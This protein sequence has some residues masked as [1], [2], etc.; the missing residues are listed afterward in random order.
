MRNSAKVFILLLTVIMAASVDR[1]ENFF[2][3]LGFC[4]CA[5]TIVTILVDEICIALR[6]RG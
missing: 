6:K 1:K 3:Y 5:V 4:T 2:R